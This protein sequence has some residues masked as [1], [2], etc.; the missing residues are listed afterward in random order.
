MKKYFIALLL[1]FIV[2]SPLPGCA[3]KHVQLVNLTILHTNDTRSHLDNIARRATVIKQVRSESTGNNVLLLDAGDI[4]SGT[5]Y[6][7]LYQGQADLWFM[8]YLHY[9]AVCLGNHEFDGG[10]AVLANFASGA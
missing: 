2:V 3:D 8:N 9:D 6:Y 1:I 7:T 10:P 4:F 5:P